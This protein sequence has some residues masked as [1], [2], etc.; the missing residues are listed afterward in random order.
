VIP[1]RIGATRYDSKTVTVGN[2][3]IAS[4]KPTKWLHAVPKQNHISSPCPIPP[5]LLCNWLDCSTTPRRAGQGRAGQGRAGQGRVLVCPSDL[6][7]RATRTQKTPAQRVTDGRFPPVKR[8][9]READHSLNVYC[10]TLTMNAALSVSPVLLFTPSSFGTGRMTVRGR[11]CPPCTEGDEPDKNKRR[12]GSAEVNR[13]PGL[14]TLYRSTV[15]C[16]S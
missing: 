16:L 12:C 13:E 9:E 1:R 8:S 15:L 3:P 5:R 11:K 6:T 14:P 7:A 4:Q 2:L 10:P